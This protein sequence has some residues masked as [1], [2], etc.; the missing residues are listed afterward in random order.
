MS[1]V[2]VF[3]NLKYCYKPRNVSF[4]NEAAINIYSTV[5]HYRI[6]NPDTVYTLKNAPAEIFGYEVEKRFS[7]YE[8]QQML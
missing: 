8:M 4:S 6:K 2:V 3:T 5:L 1:N 7:L